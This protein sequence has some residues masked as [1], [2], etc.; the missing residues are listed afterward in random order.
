MKR[1]RQETQQ[2]YQRIVQNAAQQIRVQGVNG[3]GIVDLMGQVGLTHGGFY[4]HFRSKDALLAEICHAGIAETLE[5]LTQAVDHAPAG[6]ELS[7]LVNTYLSVAHRDHP[8]T[9]CVM[10][11]LAADVARRPEEVRTAFTE[12]YE[13]LLQFVA[14][15]MPEDT[16]EKRYDAAIALLAEMV[17]AVLLSRTV[18]DPALSERILRVNRDFSLQ[19]FTKTSPENE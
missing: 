1:S 10:P 5:K 7:A 13:K 12:G 8:A 3:V 6:T 14:S 9:G 11:T 2:T 4:A 19:T 15:V 17:G 16:D 18:N